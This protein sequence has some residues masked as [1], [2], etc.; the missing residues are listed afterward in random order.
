MADCTANAQVAVHPGR[1]R[2]H[3]QERLG[4]PILGRVDQQPI[5]PDGDHQVALGKDIVRQEGT[6]DDVLLEAARQ[7]ARHGGH[8][9][10]VACVGGVVFVKAAALLLDVEA[11]LGARVEALGQLVQR[12][13]LGHQHNS[14]D[15]HNAPRWA[16]TVGAF[17]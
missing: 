6:V 11:G 5:R 9:G 13:L 8:G 7:A 15:G 12:R 2:V 10:G 14:V 17:N 3:R 1:V 16:A 4:A